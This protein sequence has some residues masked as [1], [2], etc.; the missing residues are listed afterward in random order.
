MRRFLG[1]LAL[2]ASLVAGL[3]ACSAGIGDVDL[4]QPDK[5]SKSL[6]EGE[7]YYRPI[8]SEVQFDGRGGFEAILHPNEQVIDLNRTVRAGD[9]AESSFTQV[10]NITPGVS[11]E[12]IPQILEAAKAG[13]LAAQREIHRRGGKRAR[14]HGVV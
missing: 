3:A 7:W 6:F 5:L 12:M 4:T 2:M 8:V 11:Q 14:M 10:L 9:S 13:T 1:N